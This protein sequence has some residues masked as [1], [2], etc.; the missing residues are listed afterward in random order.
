MK[1]EPFR[2]RLLSCMRMCVIDMCLFFL[3]VVRG[4]VGEKYGATLLAQME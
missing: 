3:L 1:D 2:V 4:V